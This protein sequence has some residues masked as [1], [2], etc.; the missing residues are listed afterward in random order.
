MHCKYSLSSHLTC[1]TLKRAVRSICN[2]GWLIF[3][4]GFPGLKGIFGL[5]GLKG[6]KGIK[7]V[8][9]TSRA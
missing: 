5:D 6:Q 7:G 2:V 3:P 9:G 8:A 1:K 4:V